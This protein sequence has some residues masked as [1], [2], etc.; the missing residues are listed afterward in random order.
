M[1][2]VFIA[3]IMQGSRLDDQIDSQNYRER[4]GAALSAHL[5]QV[6]V[7]D[8]WSLHPESVEYD[9]EQARH[10]FMELTALAAS[11]DVVIAYLPHASM[12]TAIEMWQAYHADNYVIAVT[13][14]VHNWVVRV[15]AHKILP[16]LESLLTYIESGR[17]RQV[18]EA[19]KDGQLPIS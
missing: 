14:M 19:R 4:I 9:D 11:A 12:G 17:L 1:M 3:G 13:P 5:P 8:P 16:D 6:H 7:S 10:T 2:H 15:T 18:L